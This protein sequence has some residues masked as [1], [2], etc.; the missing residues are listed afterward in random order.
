MKMNPLGL[1]LGGRVK[2]EKAMR[3]IPT[4]IRRKPRNM[5]FGSRLK[6][7]DAGS[8]SATS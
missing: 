5:S 2:A 6:L 3:S 7:V 1:P 4:T 8:A